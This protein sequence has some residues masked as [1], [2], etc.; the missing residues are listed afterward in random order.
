MWIKKI[1]CFIFGHKYYRQYYQD[2]GRSQFG[3][4]ICTRCG[5]SN[6][7][8]YDYSQWYNK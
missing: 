3:E 1:L 2:N 6:T 5:D 8:Q 7:W 4:D